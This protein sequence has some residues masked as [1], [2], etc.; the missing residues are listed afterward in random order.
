MNRKIKLYTLVVVLWG[1]LPLHRD[2]AAAEAAVEDRSD[3][4]TLGEIVISGKREG[5][6]ASETVY[7]VTA[8]DIRDKGARTLDQAI[9]LLPGVNVRTGGEG[10]PRIDIRGFRTRHVV[11]LLDGIPLNS[12]FDQQ[13]DPTI[14][15]TEN[16]A[17]IKL[18]AGASSLLY[19]QGGLG[20]VI[21]I[22]TQKGRAGVQGG[23]TLETGDHAPYQTKGTLSGAKGMADFFI[24]RW[25][26]AAIF[27]VDERFVPFCHPDRAGRPVSVS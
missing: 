7:T 21:N 5:V 1:L 19:G 25:K 18:T 16:I 15:P 9:A 20:G 17:E 10:V 8:G 6:Q 14:I 26:K 3:M 4:Y 24:S 11:L 23:L 22:I 2:A 12:A 13:F 27:M